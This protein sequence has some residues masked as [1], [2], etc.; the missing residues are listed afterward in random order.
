MARF[1]TAGAFSGAAAIPERR[2]AELPVTVGPDTGNDDAMTVEVA[3]QMIPVK[4]IIAELRCT[5]LWERLLC[6]I[7]FR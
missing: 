4:A 6:Q 5:R 3:T 7:W 1:T 2:R